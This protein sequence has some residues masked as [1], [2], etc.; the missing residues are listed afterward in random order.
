MNTRLRQAWALGTLLGLVSIADTSGATLAYSKADR[1][2]V[3]SRPGYVGEIITQLT[4]GEELRIVGT[5][6]IAKPAPD[7][8][9]TWYKIELAETAPVWVSAEYVDAD[10]KIV[11]AD[12]LNARAGPSLDHA[13]VARVKRGT[14]LRL[15][16]EVREGW[17]QVGA[18]AGAFGFVPS[19]WVTFDAAGAAV[20]LTPRAAVST[21]A[22]A[23]GT[24]PVK[25]ASPAA[26][27]SAPASPP[28]SVPASA[29]SSDKPGPSTNVP[30]AAAPSAGGAAA[31]QTAPPVPIVASTTTTTT[32]TTP[33]KPV[34]LA[35][36]PV[37]SPVSAP[38]STNLATQP[39]VSS[40]PPAPA[41][42]TVP[43][44]IP[45]ATI[46]DPTPVVSASAAEEGATMSAEAEETQGRRV[47]REGVVIRP[48][49]VKAPTHFALKARDSGKTINFLF[50][51]RSLPINWRDHWG[52]VVWITGREYLDQ[53]H[54]W[55]GIPLLDVEDI[56]AVR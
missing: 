48:S 9:P 56:E 22:A 42:T 51:S 43:A 34:T 5:N 16:G 49:N 38:A 36:P 55:R 28:S 44:A 10:T 11:K 6:L 2:N 50:A 23:T 18:P 54:L 33:P 4:R 53:R 1:V 13:S 29:P 17:L 31:N 40:A 20:P 8:P 41:V 39:V 37:T 32:T 30:P 14:P 19:T 52:K 47:R 26:A 45:A 46:D 25:P 15:L 35:P 24:V 21:N 12:V 3:R 7:E 27:T